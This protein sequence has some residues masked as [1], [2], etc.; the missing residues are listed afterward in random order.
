V[1]AG[2]SKD[3]EQ[4]L[5]DILPTQICT[6][7]DN[8]QPINTSDTASDKVANTASNTASDIVAD[9]ASHTVPADRASDIVSDTDSDIVAD[10]SSHTVPA[11]RTS[12]TVADTASDIAF[13]T[14]SDTVSADKASDT[15]SDTVADTAYDAAS[16][17]VSADKASDTVADTAYE[18]GSGKYDLKISSSVIQGDRGNLSSENSPFF[19]LE[20]E[21]YFSKSLRVISKP[22]NSKS[23]E[24]EVI[25][26]EM[27]PKD[28]SSQSVENICESADLESAD[29]KL[30]K[31]S[32]LK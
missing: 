16:E 31:F 18:A 12:E 28:K 6:F 24:N 15:I 11:D 7:I 19:D 3:I 25:A 4:L 27:S 23:L 10:T 1:I 17:N 22:A 9:T 26:L 14:A 2:A 20:L 5:N 13:D 21:N 29:L 30:Q 32:E 8:I